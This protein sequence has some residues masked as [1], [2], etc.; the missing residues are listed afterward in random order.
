MADAPSL[1]D[2]LD[3]VIALATMLHG[4]QL[5]KSGR[6]YLG[7][8]ERVASMVRH[9]G[10]SWVQEAAAWLHD[11]IEDTS[12]TP[13]FL[14]QTGVPSVVVGVVI[15][16]THPKGMPNDEYC[17]QVKAHPGAT[18]VK[19][20]DVYDNLNPSRMCYLDRAAQVRLRRKYAN[21]I[22]ILMEDE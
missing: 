18:L 11:S 20:A 10:G 17:R 3:K 1:Q 19:L 6:P 4:G 7:H 12:A 21:A 5:D 8:L 16:L 2:D 15:A 9:S 14:I 22:L 13:E